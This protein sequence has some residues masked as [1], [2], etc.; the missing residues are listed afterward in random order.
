MNLGRFRRYDVQASYAAVLSA[1][2][3]A[4]LVGGLLLALR[5]YKP[6]L[7]QIV[8]GA[9][10]YFVPAYFACIVASLLPGALGFVLGWSSAGQRRNDKPAHSWLGFFLGGGVVTLDIILVIAF[11]MLRFKPPS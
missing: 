10:G 9:R 1:L 11:L 2:A 7:G 8:Y 5:N 4:P 3:V 6:E